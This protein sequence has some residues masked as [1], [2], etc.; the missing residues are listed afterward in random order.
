MG[1]LDDVMATSTL[2]SAVL[3]LHELQGPWEAPLSC[4][5]IWGANPLPQASRVTGKL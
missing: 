1:S 2:L 4:A 3:M 5:R